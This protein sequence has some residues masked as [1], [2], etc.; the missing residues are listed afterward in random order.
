M[1]LSSIQDQ[2][3]PPA[4]KTKSCSELDF[5]LNEPDEAAMEDS[6]E[7]E[8]A[9]DQTASAPTPSEFDMYMAAEPAG[10]NEDPLEWWMENKR[11]FPVL[12]KLALKYLCIP[13]TSVSS[14]R[15][16]STAGDIVTASRSCLSTENVN[17]LLFLGK[18]FVEPPASDQESEADFAVA[19]NED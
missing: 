9:E 1:P 16:F 8:A 13:A 6:D 12:Y 5:L 11:R 17:M 3:P 15:V 7:T 14:E 18:K 19:D 2:V 10:N 4:K